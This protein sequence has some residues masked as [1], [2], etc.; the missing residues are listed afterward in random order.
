MFVK[1]PKLRAAT[2]PTYAPAVLDSTEML[3]NVRFVIVALGSMKKP[4][5]DETPSILM[6]SNDLN[7][8]EIIP[9]NCLFAS[10]ATPIGLK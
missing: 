4:S 1:V 3:L 7:S 10:P 9:L 8:P 6:L 5:L 2:P